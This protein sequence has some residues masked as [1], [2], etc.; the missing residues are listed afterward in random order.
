MDFGCGSG[1]SGQVLKDKYGYDNLTGLDVS[2]DMLNIARQRNIYKT[3]ISAFV[4]TDRIKQIQD[5]EYDAVISPGMFQTG[6]VRANAL[7][8]I[9]RWIKPGNLSLLWLL[10]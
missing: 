6:H 5:G 1:L 9:T 2:E 3:L 4:G 10:V 8:E 7:D